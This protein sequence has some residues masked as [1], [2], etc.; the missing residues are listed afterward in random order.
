MLKKIRHLQK[1]SD[2]LILSFLNCKRAE[3]ELL[4]VSATA[5]KHFLM[6]RNSN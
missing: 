5:L 4:P 6:K 2:V 3:A 1:I